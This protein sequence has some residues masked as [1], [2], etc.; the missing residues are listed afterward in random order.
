M[1]RSRR[2]AIL[3]LLV[4]AC[5]SKPA[6]EL[7]YEILRDQTYAPGLRCDLFV[8]KGQGPFPVVLMVHGGGW[9]KGEPADMDD[10]ARRFAEEGYAVVNAGY[11][12]APAHVFPAQ[13][14][15]LTSALIWIRDQAGA[16]RWDARR[17]S[18]FG[19]SAGA[20]LALMLAYAPALGA[21]EARVAPVSLPRVR[22]VVAGGAPT[23][24]G[25]LSDSRLVRDFMGFAIEKNPEAYR[26]ASPLH[27]A[28]QSSVPTFLFHGTHDWVVDVKH[29]R[30][31]KKKLE[32]AGV[33]V[34]YAEPNLGHIYNF[35]YNE[36]EITQALIFL[37]GVLGS[38]LSTRK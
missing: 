11:R 10:L 18:L 37:D 19:Y 4:A 28:G 27:W 12:F 20:H 38:G 15:D 31:L 26:R 32:E 14:G 5:A 30:D 9:Y 35:L 29:S 13:L 25:R 21:S 1:S 24:L 16:R 22:A 7:S 23:D 6:S 2:L 33:P 34:A 3:A 17:L 36:A 8:P